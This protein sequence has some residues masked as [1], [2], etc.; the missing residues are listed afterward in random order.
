MQRVQGKGEGMLNL[1]CSQDKL[2]FFLFSVR[3]NSLS[4]EYE[5]AYCY[6]LRCIELRSPILLVMTTSPIWGLTSSI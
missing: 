2:D 1:M 5:A 6:M 4:F 3:T